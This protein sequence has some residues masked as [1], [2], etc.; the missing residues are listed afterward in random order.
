MINKLKLISRL[1]IMSVCISSTIVLWS[2]FLIA[3]ITESKSVT[4]TIDTF[5]EA[6]LELGLL[7][8]FVVAVLFNINWIFKL[9]SNFLRG[10][11]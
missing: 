3:Y 5:N 1:Y 8:L 4:V 9:I 6:N 11:N 7:I 2:T 10:E